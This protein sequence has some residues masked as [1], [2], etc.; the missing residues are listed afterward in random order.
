[1]VCDHSD[2]LAVGR[3]AGARCIADNARR[4]SVSLRSHAWPTSGQHPT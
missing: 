4:R 2:I 1:M 3:V